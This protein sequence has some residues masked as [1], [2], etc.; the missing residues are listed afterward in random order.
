MTRDTRTC[1]VTGPDVISKNVTHEEVTKQNSRRHDAQFD[2]RL[3]HFVSR[4]DADCLAWSA[5]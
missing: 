5:S 1:S 3:A 2:Q 4:D